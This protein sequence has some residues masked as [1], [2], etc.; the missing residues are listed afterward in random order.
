M[1]TF[2][3]GCDHLKDLKDYS[4]F[5]G[6]QMG[7]S[8]GHSFLLGSPRGLWCP[9]EA[10]LAPAL[11]RHSLRAPQEIMIINALGFV[12]VLRLQGH[13]RRDGV[14]VEKEEEKTG[15]EGGRREGNDRENTATLKCPW[16]DE[17]VTAEQTVGRGPVF[18]ETWL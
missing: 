18:G 11:S 3:A 15:S 4:Y 13:A 5:V 16:P 2:I 1:K 17:K 8:D 7:N 10:G 12:P 6:F 14:G 9:R